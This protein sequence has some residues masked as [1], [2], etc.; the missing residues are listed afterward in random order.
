M[1]LLPGDYIKS[2]IKCHYKWTGQSGNNLSLDHNFIPFGNLHTEFID[3][4]QIEQT[5]AQFS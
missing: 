5:N 1:T 4:I 3:S 2:G